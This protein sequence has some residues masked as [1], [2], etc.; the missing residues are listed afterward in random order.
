MK[1][2]VSRDCPGLALTSNWDFECVGVSRTRVLKIYA[3]EHAGR[4]A[5]EQNARPSMFRCR[6]QDP[7]CSAFPLWVRKTGSLRSGELKITSD[8]I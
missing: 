1:E 2:I 6:V 3:K 5:C 8:I 7:N 4:H